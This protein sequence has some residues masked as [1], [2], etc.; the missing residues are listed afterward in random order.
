MKP[1]NHSINVDDRG[2][3]RLPCPKRRTNSIRPVVLG[4]STNTK[5]PTIVKASADTPRTMPMVPSLE[6]LFDDENTDA[7]VVGVGVSQALVIIDI[8]KVVVICRLVLGMEVNEAV[9][10]KLVGLA[11]FVVPKSVRMQGQPCV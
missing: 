8:N 11:D 10:W 3:M 9:V 1:H 5:K 6:I 7:P 4:L 2:Q